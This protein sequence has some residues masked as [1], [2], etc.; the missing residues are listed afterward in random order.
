METKLITNILNRDR[1]ENSAKLMRI[2][3]ALAVL[4]CTSAAVGFSRSK[5]NRSSNFVEDNRPPLYLPEVKYTRLITGGYDTLASRVLWFNTINYFGKQL[6]GGKDYRWLGHMCQLVT[7]LDRK[8]VYAGEFC[9]TLLPWMAKDYNTAVKVLTTTIEANPQE[10]RPYYLRGFVYW[11]FL[12]DLEHA[13]TDFVTSSKLPNAPVFLSTLASRMMAE[14]RGPEM[15]IQF[16]NEMITNSTDANV[17]KALK[18]KRKQARLRLA[19]ETISK[20]SEQFFQTNNRYPLSVEELLSVALLK[21]IPKDP[22]K[23]AFSID[24][25]T[26]TVSTSSNKRALGFIGRTAKNSPLSQKEEAQR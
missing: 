16:L 21:E 25:K 13:K 3:A 10:W 9:G 11:Y 1:G 24:Q 7:E 4:L 26:G 18:R 6:A 22:Y 17:I 19:I 20:A 2:L 12:E 8:A 15:A 5:L 14:A 23:G